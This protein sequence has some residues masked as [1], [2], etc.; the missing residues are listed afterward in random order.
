MSEETRRNSTSVVWVFGGG[1]TGLSVAH[2]C[3]ERGYEVY[4]V[5]P[6]EDSWD[7]DLP[8]V[9]GL[10]RTQWAYI[11]TG[12]TEE[13]AERRIAE[14]KKGEERAA[15]EARQQGKPTPKPPEDEGRITRAVPF[16][17]HPSFEF[18]L[19]EI[20]KV[21][22][23]S[24]DA[25]PLLWERVVAELKSFTRR[26]G[27]ATRGAGYQALTVVL[28]GPMKQ[29]VVSD[30]EGAAAKVLRDHAEA[31]R[32]A[33]VEQLNKCLEDERTARGEPSRYAEWADAE[34]EDDILWVDALETF[35]IEVR[36]KGRGVVPG[37]HG[38]RYFP[39]FYRHLFDTMRRTP[40]L[41]PGVDRFGPAVR[42]VFDNLVSTEAT[43][44][45][46]STENDP[47][48]SDD[49]DAAGDKQAAAPTKV[50]SGGDGVDEGGERDDD[51]DDAS[52]PVE[53]SDGRATSR[54][55][56]VSFPRRPPRS[57]QQT[58]KLLESFVRELGYSAQDV[59]RISTKLFQY[60]TSSSERRAAE[61]ED[62]TWWDFIEGERFTKTCRRHMELGPEVLGA[63]TASESE[64]RT[65]GNCVTQLLIDQLAGRTITDAT[66]NGPT[67]VAWFDPW[68]DYLIY[69][70]VKFLRGALVD[71]KQPDGVAELHMPDVLLPRVVVDGEDMP[72][73]NFDTA[74]RNHYFVIATPLSAMLDLPEFNLVWSDQRRQ[75]PVAPPAAPDPDP[76]VVEAKPEEGFGLARKFNTAMEKVRARV[77]A[78][79]LELKDSA[80][81][82][83]L[84]PEQVAR[85]ERVL[86]AL[87]HTSDIV[88]LTEWQDEM[89]KAKTP[90]DVGLG[91]LRHLTGV[92]YLFDNNIQFGQEHTLY[93][94]APWRLSSISQAHFWRR[95]P[96]GV[97][98]YRGI[99]SVDIGALHRPATV[100][101]PS[102]DPGYA[103]S[104]TVESKG[105]DCTADEIGHT[106]WE[107]VRESVAVDTQGLR[108]VTSEA[109]GDGGI[110]GMPLGIG[111]RVT[112]RYGQ[113]GGKSKGASSEAA[114]DVLVGGA[115]NL[116]PSCYHLD[117]SIIF[118]RDLG[119]KRGIAKNLSPYL[120]NRPGEWKL[121][122]GRIDPKDQARGYAMQNGRWVLAGT[123]M[124][125]FTRLTT[126]ESANE[127]ARHAV[128]AILRAS[129]APGDRCKIWNPEEMEL[130]DF[131]D[132]REIDRQ[133]F[134][135][136]YPHMV[137]ILG[138]DAIPE[139]LLPRQLDLDEEDHAHRRPV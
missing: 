8:A 35:R 120:I 79:E 80:S 103:P 81:A 18:T 118:F 46:V 51:D 119:E 86:K 33:I 50:A 91:P 88:A 42:T 32:E 127:S 117:E 122:P 64:T 131:V 4:L 5:E 48:T 10:A 83:G 98:G 136:G 22:P 28:L 126:M 15:L 92:Q 101:I 65:Q 124:K 6:A 24:A 82:T 31:V 45:A 63:M 111:K 47:Q 95:R 39:G 19:E 78:R 128:N 53:A 34:P 43:W 85:Q 137:E 113:R 109:A 59:S 11:P 90:R 20:K 115:R 132:L 38:F 114:L 139:A 12:E 41:Q 87:R 56:L 97:Y 61:F 9:G 116:L 89:A 62:L 30:A 55:R 134:D 16:V 17:R 125:T 71:F 13:Q 54:Q 57:I 27:E 110:G 3:I 60:M 66:L 70:G 100:T 106:V 36:V 40:I 121:R 23:A 75:G 21:S 29:S 84:T 25:D 7:D 58:L 73:E 107:Q 133:L 94:D 102:K 68:R 130:P 104:T 44:L 74:L 138:I 67:S 112:P 123:Y 99:V 52:D 76:R 49:K 14:R 108:R 135:S 77:E 2:E 69:R 105:W 37:E 129:G 72:L 1:I 96:T 93:M 26:V